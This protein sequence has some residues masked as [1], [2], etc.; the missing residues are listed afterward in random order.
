MSSWVYI[1]SQFTPE[2]LLFE[3]LIITLLCGGYTV[4]WVLR[5]RRFGVIEK[6]LPSGPVKA[7]LNELITNAEQLRVQLFGLLSEHPDLS[8]LQR[9]FIPSTASPSATPHP[10]LSPVNLNSDPNLDKK[11]AELEAKLAEQDTAMN[12]ITKDKEKVEKE[13]A[14]ALQRANS[15]SAGDSGKE[16]ASLQQKIHDLEERLAEYSVIE[17]DLANLKRLQQEN[18]QL[19]S[20]LAS[21]GLSA[22]DV[23]SASSS[24]PESPES[25]TPTDEIAGGEP[26]S[27]SIAEPAAEPAVEPVLEPHTETPEE[28]KA[29]GAPA[30]DFANLANQVQESL[31]TPAAAP[32]PAEPKEEQADAD[33]VAEFE[34]MLNG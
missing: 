17:D 32:K 9:S 10:S 6:D 12:K 1:F 2:A 16:V 34:K 5:K 4:F 15:A 27:E 22:P 3:G 24:S 8:Q 30:D 31:A 19:K 33:L 28:P 26:G 23:T 13:L 21:K 14:D 29:N 25:S 20:T 18:A 11:L 7:Y